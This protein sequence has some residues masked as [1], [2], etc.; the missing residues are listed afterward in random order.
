MRTQWMWVA[1]SM[2][3]LQGCG[4]GK[5]PLADL[6]I[7]E[8]AKRLEGQVYRLD[9]AELKAS[10]A[11]AADGNTTFKGKVILKPGTSGESMQTMDCTVAAAA[12]DAPAQ[13]RAA[14]A[15]CWRRP[16]GRRSHSTTPIGPAS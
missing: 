11:D 13:W 1:V 2:L 16:R 4:G 8:A 5:D 3:A 10:K 6:C 14:A 12:G 7:A 15:R 9:E